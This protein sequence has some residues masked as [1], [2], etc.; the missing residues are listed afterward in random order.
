MENNLQKENSFKIVGKLTHADVKCATS[1]KTGQN[2]VS[3]TA[4]IQSAVNGATYEYEVAFY[5]S[6]KKADG[7]VS[8]LYATYSKLDELEGHKVEVT[9][10]LRENRYFSAKSNEM[11]SKQELAGR[12]IKGIADATPDEGSWI[13]SG[14]LLKPVAERTNKNNEVYRYDVSMGQANYKG[15]SMSQYTFHIDPVNR[16]I[17]K[18]VSSYTAGQTFRLQGILAFTVETITK[19]SNE[20]G[21]FGEPIVRT[22]TNRQKNFYITG[23]SGVIKDDTAYDT[24]TAKELVAAYKAHDAE[25]METAKS[26]NQASA[27]EVNNTITSRQESLI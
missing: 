1:A 26:R 9:G 25:I 13:L 14:F 24:P 4:T 19:S 8:K 17:Y 7:S 12:F 2:Y 21:G 15:D 22:Y 18:A 20:E 5:S 6:E 3:A 27:V 23:G 11:C 16:E 10:S